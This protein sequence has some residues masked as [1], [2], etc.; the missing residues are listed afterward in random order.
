MASEVEIANVAL[1]LLGETRI[2]SLDDNI[3]QAREAKAIF[4]INR[5]ALLSAYTWS[6]A[7]KRT[8]LSALVGTPPFEFG[9]KY[10]LPA[11]CLRV[12]F[13][14]DYYAGLD[15][16]DYR[17][18]PNKEFTIEGREILTNL[19]APLNLQYVYRV[20]DTAAWQSA[21]IKAFSCNLAM[22]LAEPL[23]QSDKKRERA[24]I[25]F[26]RAISDAVRTNAIELPPEKMPDDEWIMSRL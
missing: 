10:Q 13:V 18:S 19:G 24:E 17:G 15:L 2:L 11:D 5:D 8:Q 21:F 1:T 14:G 20:T 16:T 12:I 9:Y 26:R 4:N 25:A 6:F 23:T 3:K 22:D 7:K